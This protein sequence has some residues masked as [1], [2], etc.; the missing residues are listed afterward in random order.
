MLMLLVML[1]CIP[2]AKPVDY[3]L[4]PGTDH[5]SLMNNDVRL[6]STVIRP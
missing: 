6:N 2:T 3:Q 5:V 4:P 1:A